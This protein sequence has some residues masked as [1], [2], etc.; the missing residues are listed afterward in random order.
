[1]KLN[2]IEHEA[3]ALS[4]RDRANLICKLL[5]TLPVAGP[6]VLD[7][8]VAERDQELQSGKVEALTH[9]EFVR[10]VQEDRRR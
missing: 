10:R 8:E 2:E 7:E 5:D 3:A 9:E 4:E 1:M 6:D